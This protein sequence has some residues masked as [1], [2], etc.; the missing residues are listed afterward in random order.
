MYFIILY[1]IESWGRKIRVIKI[2]CYKHGKGN[3]IVRTK[4]ESTS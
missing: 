1:S 3:E 2:T 4:K